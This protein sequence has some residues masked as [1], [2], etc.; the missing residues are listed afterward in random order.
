VGSSDS[1]ILYPAGVAQTFGQNGGDLEDFDPAQP[2]PRFGKSESI[3]CSTL[4]DHAV[5]QDREAPHES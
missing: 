4:Q 3:V 5:A 1:W 2:P